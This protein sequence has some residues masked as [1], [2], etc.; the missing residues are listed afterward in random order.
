MTDI[1]KIKEYLKGGSKG[2][3][4]INQGV[5]SGIDLRGANLFQAQLKGAN[6]QDANLIGADLKGTILPKSTRL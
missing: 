3:V 6:L 5:L 1:E 4:E 2:V